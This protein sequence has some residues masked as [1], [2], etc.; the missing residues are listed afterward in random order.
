MQN[1]QQPSENR[2]GLLGRLRGTL[3]PRAITQDRIEAEM[4]LFCEPKDRGGALG[5]FYRFGYRCHVGFAALF[6]FGLGGPTSLTEASQIPL[7]ITAAWRLIVYWRMVPTMIT[8]PMIALALLATAWAWISATWSPAGHLWLQDAHGARFA[9]LIIGL[10]PVLRERRLLLLALALGFLAGNASQLL[11]LLQVRG[12]TEFVSFSR[13]P[14]RISGWWDPVVGG[15]LLTAM[16]TMHASVALLAPTWTRTR[17][18][19]IALSVTTGIGLIATGTRGAWIAGMLALGAL[20]LV[21]ICRAPRLRT[22]VIRAAAVLLI[23]AG[24]GAAAWLS[25]GDEIGGRIDRARTEI[26]NAIDAGDYASDTGARLMMWSLAIEAFAEHPVRGV[27]AGGYQVWSRTAL[28]GR[29]GLENA[30]RINI[31][32]H[33]HSSV[34]HLASTQGI[35][36]LGVWAILIGAAFWTVCGSRPRLIPGTYAGAMPFLMFGLLLT[37]LTDTTQTNMQTAA[38]FW[39]AIA[40]TPPRRPRER[41]DLASDPGHPPPWSPFGLP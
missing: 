39:A 27:G 28:D 21:W 29:D 3:F 9:W 20:T 34:L 22:T 19:A 12:I 26:S 30:D 25:I 31:H 32:D 4:R 36:G 24:G 40:L 23:G 8:S 7:A 38:M 14:S 2:S 1:A 41:Q 5:P 18:A 33:A 13:D 16:L 15:S 37:G 11:H 35:V 10:L 17:Y 6:C